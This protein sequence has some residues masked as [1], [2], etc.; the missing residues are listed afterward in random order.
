M[1]L[2]PVK[3]NVIEQLTLTGLYLAGPEDLEHE[4]QAMRDELLSVL[5][6]LDAAELFQKSLDQRS[7]VLMETCTQR[8][9]PS[10]QSP[11]DPWGIVTGVNT[12][13]S[14]QKHAESRYKC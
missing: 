1:I 11:R 6:F 5:L 2:V 9:Q 12:H 4:R 3:S 13:D 8:L 14:R 7:A 10:V